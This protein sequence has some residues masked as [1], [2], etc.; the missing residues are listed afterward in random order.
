MAAVDPWLFDALHRKKVMDWY[1]LDGRCRVGIM[2]DEEVK[3]HKIRSLL[4]DKEFIV[5]QAKRE[6]ELGGW[7]T[8]HEKAISL[9]N[10]ELKEL[11]I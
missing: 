10:E 9:I 6:N 11:G 4:A 5:A 8:D 2:T 3:E 7:R 1:E